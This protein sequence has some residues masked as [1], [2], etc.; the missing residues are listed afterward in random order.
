MRAFLKTRPDQLRLVHRHYP[1]KRHPY[2]LTY[3]KMAYCAGRQG[4]FWPANDYLFVNGRR[5][6]PV[7]AREL[8][9]AVGGDAGELAACME[10]EAAD[11][12]VR[13]DATEAH[14]LGV[15]G[16]PTYVIDNRTYPGGI[17]REVIAQKLDE[18]Q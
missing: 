13:Q 12:A 2:A 4:R 7:T 5:E 8:V 9:E 3:A 15:R 1:L 18:G 17:P 14:G 11:Q 6:S 10:S 16:T